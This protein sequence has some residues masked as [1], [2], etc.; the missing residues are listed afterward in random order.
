M[1]GVAASPDPNDDDSPADDQRP[2]R[3]K[4]VFDISLW[5]LPLILVAVV[6]ALVLSERLG[7]FGF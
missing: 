6:I 7:L 3:D 5:W 1:A 2:R 4:D